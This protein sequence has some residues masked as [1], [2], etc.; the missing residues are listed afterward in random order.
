[1]DLPQQIVS[2]K[3][4]MDIVMSQKAFKAL[5]INTQWANNLFNLD[6]IRQTRAK[7]KGE[8]IKVAILDT[9]IDYNHPDLENNIKGGISIINDYSTDF[10]DEN[11]HG[12]HCAGI[13][14]AIENDI[15]VTGVAPK[16]DLYGIQILGKNGQ[17]S[18]DTITKGIYW[19]IENKMKIISMSLGGPNDYKPLHIAIKKA[20]E[21]DI[22]VVVAAGN[23]GDG[24]INTNEF[25]YPGDYN[26][27]ITIGAIDPEKHLANFSNTNDEVKIT[28]PG[29]DIYSTLP[30]GNYGILSGT[31]MA[32]PFVSGIIALMLSENPSLSKWQI[33]TYLY[34]T[35]EEKGPKGKND[36]FGWG[37]INPDGIFKSLV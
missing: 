35:A 24:N 14:G 4:E 17:G 2:V 19:A 1:M 36:G 27:V 29:V 10:I 21:N 9:G 8:G 15:G 3:N 5:T 34:Q 32:C 33:E 6:E 20:V 37:I 26:E 30:K 7:N 31:S 13:I 25:S 23:E 11:G 18:W 12:S 22:I 16:C 28:A